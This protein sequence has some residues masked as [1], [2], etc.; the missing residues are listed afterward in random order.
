MH[1][2]EAITKMIDY[3]ILEGGIEIAGIDAET[4]EM[5]YKFTP[6]LKDLMPELYE[7]HL[8]ILNIEMMALWEKG[9]VEIDLF[10]EDPVVSLTKKS[11]DPQE[12]GKLTREERW[13]LNE[14]IRVFNE[15]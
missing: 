5:L 14:L 1:D 6:K 13:S 3:L 10:D 12:V 9:Y 15:K 11:L 7:E 4:S 2:N 8:N